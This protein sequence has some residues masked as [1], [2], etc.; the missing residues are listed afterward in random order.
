MYALHE[1]PSA[2]PPP[3]LPGWP[4]SSPAGSVDELLVP[5]GEGLPED[6]VLVVP[7]EHAKRPEAR[8]KEDRTTREWRS[9]GFEVFLGGFGRNA[10]AT[11]QEPAARCQSQEIDG[12]PQPRL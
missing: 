4:A 9:M 5:V 8:A 6:D 1:G 7:A 2:L 12:G 11:H 3:P 10:A